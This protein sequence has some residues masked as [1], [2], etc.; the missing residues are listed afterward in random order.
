MAEEEVHLSSMAMMMSNFS[1]VIY[2]SFLKKKKN[3]RE[4]TIQME[5]FSIR[6]DLL[7]EGFP[8]PYS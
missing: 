2:Y 3:R 5:K 1:L 6:E 7:E 4:K 8:P